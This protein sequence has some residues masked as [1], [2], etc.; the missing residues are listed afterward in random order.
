MF[1]DI[2][3]YTA[4][5][6]TSEQQG[7]RLRERHRS[8]L[9]SMA[10]RYR[11]EVVDEN[12]DELVVSFPSACDAV[13]CALAAQAELH[14][15]TELQLCI[16]IHL[17]DVLF[18]GGRIYGDGVNVASRIRPFAEPGGICVSESVYE[19][20]K[21]QANVSSTSLGRKQL[22]NVAR[23]MEIFAVSGTVAAP[24]PEP[25]AGRP[26]AARQ[27]RGM[28]AALATVAVVLAAIVLA[29]WATWPRPLGLA[30]K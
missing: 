20:V 19:S 3:G 8:A 11:G 12:G 22:K 16:G 23:P 14:D 17:G 10:A 15:D 6:A 30:L 24:Q 26:G 29:T 7:L 21:N 27:W 1:S 9:G 5:M 18:D 2:V 13:N 28:R 25:T 4:Q